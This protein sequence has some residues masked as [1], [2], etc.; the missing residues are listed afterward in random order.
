M[1]TRPALERYRSSVPDGAST[2]SHLGRVGARANPKQI[3]EERVTFAFAAGFAPCLV[4]DLDARSEDNVQLRINALR[5]L[6][7]QMTSPV[8]AGELVK[9][10]CLDVLLRHAVSSDV[11][12]RR[13]AT[14]AMTLVA[15]TSNGKLAFVRSGEGL[16]VLLP[17]LDDSDTEARANFYKTM[18]TLCSN[19]EATNVL[20]L[21]GV[22]R[23]LVKKARR[24]EGEIQELCLQVLYHTLK[25]HGE[26]ALVEAQE[27]GA[28]GLC[29]FLMENGTSSP[30]V[31]ELAAKNL[32]L[33][34]FTTQAK[35]KL[36]ELDAVKVVCKLLADS[37][38]AVRAAAA[39]AL[40]GVTT[41]KAAKVTV[42]E[43]GGLKLLDGLL[44]DPSRMVQLNT[45]KT[46]SNVVVHPE[47][48]KM[49][50]NEKTV[51]RLE[52]LAAVDDRLASRAAAT[53][54]ALVLWSP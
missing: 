16:S 39:G 26:T 4:N 44:N 40:M 35:L 34:C 22:V 15:R 37:S 12:V 54:L 6:C 1:I 46:L 9:S 25:S 21:I 10:G 11:S 48:R 51:A 14:H 5:A 32:T 38:Y 27:Q 7:D 13:L 41:E 2:S 47:A 29:V 17:L 24:E 53:C 20:V 52:E 19:A 8:P 3:P 23:V 30:R 45:L 28:T 31:K 42:I 43:C 33:L 50:N 18:L 49:L 36:I